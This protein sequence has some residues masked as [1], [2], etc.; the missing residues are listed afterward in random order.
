MHANSPKQ[1][2]NKLTAEAHGGRHDLCTNQGPEFMSST[3]CS[4][5]RCCFTEKKSKVLKPVLVTHT[6]R[7]RDEDA[8]TE[9]DY[10][11]E[12]YCKAKTVWP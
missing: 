11:F 10:F 12:A 5:G 2:V 8:D 4:D 9:R 7:A 6:D 3:I 1:E